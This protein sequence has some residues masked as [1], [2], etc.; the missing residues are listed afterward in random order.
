MRIYLYSLTDPAV[1]T[2]RGLP[3]GLGGTP[4]ATITQGAVA[5]VIG[6]VE[7][8]PSP[9]RRGDLERHDMVNRAVLDLGVCVPLRYGTMLP[10]REDCM[11]LLAQHAVHWNG[12]LRRLHGRVELSMRAVF[13]IATPKVDEEAIPPGIGPG[14]DYLR[15]RQVELLSGRRMSEYLAALRDRLRDDLGGIA[16]AILIEEHSFL[17]SVA[18]LLPREEFSRGIAQVSAIMAGTGARWQIA[19]PWPPY[20]FVAGLDTAET[21]GAREERPRG[22]G[23]ELASQLPDSRS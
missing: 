4:V 9:V 6:E 14:T 16:D 18:A 1:A 13:P 2:G 20:S 3:P 10:G 11:A 17:L 15:R 21:R 5:A 8:L 12:E 23:V 22:G 19:P 7:R